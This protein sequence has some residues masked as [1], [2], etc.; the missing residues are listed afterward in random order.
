MLKTPS[1]KTRTLASYTVSTVWNP[2][3]FN[4]NND[5]LRRAIYRAAKYS[6]DTMNE[7]YVPKKTGELINSSKL[8][9][10]NDSTVNIIWTSDYASKVYYDKTKEVEYYRGPFWFDR[11][12]DIYARRIEEEATKSYYSR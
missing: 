9:R 1:N 12:I 5:R 2:K 3:S 11:M 7:Y 6:M 10:I 8:E 4:A